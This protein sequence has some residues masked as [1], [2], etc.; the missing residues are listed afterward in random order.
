MESVRIGDEVNA[1]LW[2][3]VTDRISGLYQKGMNLSQS[4]PA[5]KILMKMKN[6]CGSAALPPMQT[7]SEEAEKQYLL[8][9][10]SDLKNISNG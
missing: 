1:Q 3:D 9:V 7:M 10:Q 2:Q 5:L 4:I 8:M 6:L